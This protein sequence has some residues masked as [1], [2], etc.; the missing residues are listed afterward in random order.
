MGK[1]LPKSEEIAGRK[2]H[3]NTWKL[4][5]NIL[6][7]TDIFLNQVRVNVCEQMVKMA[8]CENF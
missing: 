3:T 6:T 8:S 2:A 1:N 5:R 7:I 4:I